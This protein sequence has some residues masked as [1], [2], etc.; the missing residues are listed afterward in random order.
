VKLHGA[1]RVEDFRELSLGRVR[2]R[3]AVHQSKQKIETLK[4]FWSN[5]LSKIIV[6]RISENDSVHLVGLK[7]RS[8]NEVAEAL[9]KNDCR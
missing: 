8:T 1:T 5:D 2:P 7:L 6:L 9:K 4:F 3:P